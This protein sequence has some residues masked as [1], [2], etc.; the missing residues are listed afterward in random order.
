MAGAKVEMLGVKLSLCWRTGRRTSFPSR[1]QPWIRSQR[2][3]AARH[4]HP[5]TPAP[6]YGLRACEKGQWQPAQVLLCEMWCA[7]GQSQPAL[8]PLC[9][10]VG[11]KVEPTIPR[12]STRIRACEKT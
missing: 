9:E 11:A 5:P 7:K 4:P 1:V 6:V 12:Y 8:A 2:L 3:L 10:M